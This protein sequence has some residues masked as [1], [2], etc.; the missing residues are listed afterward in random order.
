VTDGA[1][2]VHPLRRRIQELVSSPT[3]DES[4][5]DGS[6]GVTIVRT[7]VIRQGHPHLGCTDRHRSRID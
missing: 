2:G 6:A 3:P 1:R 5:S 7:P 4:G